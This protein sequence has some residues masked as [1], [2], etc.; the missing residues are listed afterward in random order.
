MS[1]RMAAWI[2][3]SASA[4]AMAV[5]G[6]VSVTRADDLD[7]ARVLMRRQKFAE[8]RSLL[9][10]AHPRSAAV[11]RVDSLRR[12]D[13]ADLNAELAWRDRANMPEH[14]DSIGR[15][16]VALRERLHGAASL[17]VAVSLSH[18]GRIRRFSN[19]PDS[20]LAT[21]SR[22][23]G[24]LDRL[25][26]RERELATGL[27]AI[28]NLLRDR[29]EFL[30]ARDAL[31]RAVAIRRR[32][33]GPRSGETAGALVNLALVQDH[34]GD[35]GSEL[36]H[37]REAIEIWRNMDPPDSLNLL[38]TLNNYAG[39]LVLVKQAS[40]ALAM[41][42]WAESL[43]VAL[44]VHPQLKFQAVQDLA[45]TLGDAGR[46]DEARTT[47]ERGRAILATGARMIPDV[48]P[49]FWSVYG[50]FER[51]QGRLDSALV[52][53]RRARS[54]IASLATE[55]PRYVASLAELQHEEGT[56]LMLR[57]DLPG[58]RRELEA[59]VASYVAWYGRE[60]FPEL[61]GARHDLVVARH[62]LGDRDS[63]L[64]S[65][66][67]AEHQRTRHLRAAFDGLSEAEALR[68]RTDANDFSRYSLALAVDRPGLEPAPA[69]PLWDQIMRS[70]A[71]VLDAM[72]SRGRFL[73]ASADSLLAPLAREIERARAEASEALALPE[74]RRSERL[75]RAREHRQSAERAF[76]DR[77]LSF[78]R[79]L[80]RQ[81][82]GFDEVARALPAGAAL[83]QYV[84]FARWDR[85]RTLA[86]IADSVRR[87][88]H[89]TR[90]IDATA[91]PAWGA[92][93]L[94]GGERTPRFVLLGGAEIDRALAAWSAGLR[95]DAARPLTSPRRMPVSAGRLARRQLWDPI[96]DLVKD[97]GV[98]LVVRDAG[99]HQVNLLTLPGADGS[100]LLESAP[101]IQVLT[102]PRDIVAMQRPAT[103]RGSFLAMGDPDYDRQP[104]R[105]DRTLAARVSRGAAPGVPDCALG[106]A[107]RFAPLPA[108]RT[109]L[110]AVQ[111]M[112]PAAFGEPVVLAG[113]AATRSA[114]LGRAPGCRALHVATHGFF[115]ADTCLG[116]AE[117]DAPLLRVGLAFA[118]AN[119]AGE[120]ALVTAAEIASLRLEG[121][122]L[123]VLSSCS[124]GAGNDID[125]EGLF[126]MARAFAL[127][128]ARTTVLSGN[129]VDDEIAALWMTRF[130]RARWSGGAT[131]AAAARDASRAVRHELLRRRLPD[132]PS[133]WGAFVPTGDWR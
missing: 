119:R 40:A 49:I 33:L 131:V 62:W 9:E 64:E 73:G 45:R 69:A 27:V 25:P 71:Q 107:R 59:S 99:L 28:G 15:A 11:S 67:A 3:S 48:A 82:V 22:S 60:E 84:R 92:F 121:L 8:A 6:A 111:A 32:V 115:L 90:A 126:G 91:I 112:C 58:A 132:H 118:G 113:S 30:K 94:R 105:A 13:L 116:V 16:A 95:G 19:Q 87:G 43:A 122:E 20:A 42:Q 110:D 65:E 75:S 103:P 52:Y 102:S 17:E 104:A 34:L 57:G 26:D 96:A 108:T 23:V 21:L 85:T 79:D 10:A 106:G 130:Y 127:A 89:S 54:V 29:G 63:L 24:I 70:H 117:G 31:E 41:A 98:L 1:R 35:R 55:D 12:A 133:Q 2:V 123:A 53:T 51:G 44:D 61:T 56:V 80:K 81:D 83:V 37:D 5:L 120:D 100:P 7:S 72:A 4:V 93:V 88:A 47:F 125:G 38:L 68:Y 109:E 66:L 129:A 77:S 76:A 14:A 124:S 46:P 101:P 74:P 114:F 128:G 18:L 97:A 36:V 39:T 86:A 50:T 78:S